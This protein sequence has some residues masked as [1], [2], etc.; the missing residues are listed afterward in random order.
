MAESDEE[1]EEEEEE[2]EVEEEEEDGMDF[3]HKQPVVARGMAATLSLLRNT[4]TSFPPSLPPPSLLSFQ[5]CLQHST[6][7]SLFPSLPPSLPPSLGEL[8]TKEKMV[9]RDKDKKVLYDVGAVGDVRREGGREGLG[10][11]QRGWEKE[12]TIHL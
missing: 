6:H 5:I 3:M 8:S 1:E 12:M 10:R 7:A 9:G 2:E 11:E 4:G